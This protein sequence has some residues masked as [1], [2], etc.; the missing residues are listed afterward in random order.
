MTSD[1][2]RSYRFPVQ[3]EFTKATVRWGRKE[4]SATLVNESAGGFL[5]TVTAAANLNPGD[6]I[7]VCIYS[8]AYLVE[9]VHTRPDGDNLLVG[10]RRFD[11][12]LQGQVR[13]VAAPRRFGSLSH[14]APRSLSAVLFFGAYA[15]IAILAAVLI[16]N[17]YGG[18]VASQWVAGAPTSDY[19]PA[20]YQLPTDFAGPIDWKAVQSLHGINSLTSEQVRRA[21]GL[22]SAQQRSLDVIFADTARKLEGLFS[23]ENGAAADTGKQS[24][25]VI[26]EAVQRVLCTLTDQQIERWRTE[27]MQ[28]AASG[29][30]A[31][32]QATS[33]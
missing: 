27:L 12:E 16:L 29:P 4:W 17:G 18:R 24:S 28:K 14:G 23:E 25:E 9:I 32:D 10:V 1:K 6:T 21:I 26:D 8:G 30:K 22:T 15:G 2:R 20:L 7:T 13:S 31:G 3:E 11:D 33:G 19:G 5:L